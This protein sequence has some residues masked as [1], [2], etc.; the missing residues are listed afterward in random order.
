MKAKIFIFSIMALAVLFTAASCL[1]TGQSSRDVDVRVTIV[2]NTGYQI[3]YLHMSP[4]ND[5]YWGDCWLGPTEVI[6]N[7][8]SKSILL[9]PLNTAEVYDVVLVD[10]DGDTYTKW[11]VRVA[12][13]M[14]IVFVFSDIDQ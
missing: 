5:S 8:E 11:N 2:N 7:G 3:W 10:I 6:N 1:T 9:P 14:T 4:S 12:P 13:N